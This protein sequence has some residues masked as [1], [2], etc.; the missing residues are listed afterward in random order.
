MMCGLEMLA[1][2]RRDKMNRIRNEYMRG[3]VQAERFGHKA[4]EA[5]LSCSGH[6][7]RRDS[8]RRRKRKDLRDLI[9]E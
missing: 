7:Q 3:T 8:G 5:R 4:R 9:H 1:L 2:T 6:V